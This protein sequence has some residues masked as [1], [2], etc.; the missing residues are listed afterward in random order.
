MKTMNFPRH[1]RA[2]AFTLIELMVTISLIAL[3]AGLALVAMRYA[4][5][6]S[7][8]EKARTHLKV[9]ESA[10]SRY[11]TDSGTLPRPKE[12]GEGQS[13]TVGG[14]T[15]PGGG[16]VALYQALSGDG[17]NL[18]EGGE[19]GSLGQMGSTADAKVYWPDVDPRSNPQRIVQQLS[20]QYMLVDPWGVPWQFRVPPP[21]DPN[22]PDQIDK[23]KYHNPTTYDLWSYGGDYQNEK[24]WIKNW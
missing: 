15:Y 16:A 7:R 2:R 21:P 5:I 10:L 18:I 19:T 24:A 8:R 6:A 4:N 12:G 11:T 17:D 20:G 13:V 3:L 1:F 9:I 14:T 23:T 22:N